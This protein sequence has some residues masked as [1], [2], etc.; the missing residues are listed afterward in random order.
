MTP[1]IDPQISNFAI[2]A[3]HIPPVSTLVN[4]VVRYRPLK[5]NVPAPRAVPRALPT[6]LFINT[7]V[8]SR[9]KFR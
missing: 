4:S 8:P 1:T 6:G 9:V 2:G 3:P 5:I 7:A